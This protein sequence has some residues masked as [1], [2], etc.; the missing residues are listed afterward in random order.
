MWYERRMW[1]EFLLLIPVFFVI[2]QFVFMYISYKFKQSVKPIVNEF[3]D[4]KFTMLPI[5]TT[6]IEL[7]IFSFSIQI[8]LTLGLFFGRI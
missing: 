2:G 3:E 8:S 1:Y 5:P 6:K 7:I 4:F